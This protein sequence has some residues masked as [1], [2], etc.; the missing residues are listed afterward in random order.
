MLA[1]LGLRA[2]PEEPSVDDVSAAREPGQGAADAW[3]DY[4][5]AAW[6]ARGSADDSWRQHGDHGWRDRSWR[7]RGTLRR[8]S[9]GRND[10][11]PLRPWET[12][13]N[14]DSGPLYRKDMRQ[15]TWQRFGEGPREAVKRLK[16]EL[17]AVFVEGWKKFCEDWA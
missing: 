16:K 8:F 17:G 1:T 4:E 3:H 6:G 10:Q 11:S 7:A 15:I 5:R 2:R 13:D 12:R 9:D 14:M